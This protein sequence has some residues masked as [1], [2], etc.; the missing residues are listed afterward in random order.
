MN[1]L[2]TQY[3]HDREEGEVRLG[4]GE[5]MDA[6]MNGTAHLHPLS[7]L[8]QLS[9][10]DPRRTSVDLYSS[11]HL[12]MQSAEMSFDL[13]NDKISFLGGAQDSFW[14]GAD[15]GPEFDEVCL[16]QAMMAKLDVLVPNE[17]KRS[18]DRVPSPPTAQDV[19]VQDVDVPPVMSPTTEM[20]TNIPL[21]MSPATASPPSMHSEWL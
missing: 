17:L 16:P 3:V 19:V 8:T 18:A 21:P 12:Q 4:R 14:A 20:A 13:L 1:E 10:D 9:P 11:F 2:S 5:N 7:T 6:D 15:D